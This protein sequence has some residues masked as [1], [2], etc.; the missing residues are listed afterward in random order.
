MPIFT[1]FFAN[2]KIP[3]LSLI[4]AASNIYFCIKTNNAKK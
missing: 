2:K 3:L 4:N 1:E